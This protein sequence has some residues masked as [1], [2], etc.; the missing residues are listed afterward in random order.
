[1]VT[2]LK[3]EHWNKIRENNKNLKELIDKIE[4]VGVTA[5][6]YEKKFPKLARLINLEEVK[7]MKLVNQTITVPK[8]IEKKKSALKIL[9]PAGHITPKDLAKE[10]KTSPK[11]LRKV[12]RKLNLT[13]TGKQWHWDLADKAIKLIKDA[14]VKSTQP[15]PET[16]KTKVEEVAP[17]PDRVTRAE[18][19]AEELEAVQDLPDTIKVPPAI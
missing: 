3:K 16:K 11:A 7:K 4:I 14:F 19:D 6:D 17:V 13:R 9:V 15:K 2:Y 12:I 1:M 5:A 8:K 18:A 10:L